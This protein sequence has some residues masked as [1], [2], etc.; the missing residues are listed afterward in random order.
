[1]PKEVPLLQ[2]IHYSDIHLAGANYVQTRWLLNRAYSTLSQDHQQGW[3]GAR[4]A[5]LDEFKLVIAALTAED[6]VWKDEPAWLVDT[7]DGTTFGDASSLTEWEE[8]TRKFELAAQ[9]YGRLMRVYG[10]H[11]G[12]PGTFPLFAPTRMEAQRDSLRNTHFSTKWPEAAWTVNVPGTSSRIELCAVNTVDHRLVP[13]TLALGVAARDH[14]W[15]LFQS[16][17]MDTPA[18]DLAQTAMALPAATTVPHLRIAAMHYPVA[19]EAT[20]GKPMGQKVLANR[21]RFADDLRSHPLLQPLVTNLLLAGHTHSPFPDLG[22]LPRSA[23]AAAHLPLVAGQ[24]QIVSGSLSQSV[25]PQAQRRPGSSWA[26]RMALDN[27]YQCTVLRFYSQPHDPGEIIMDRT[28]LGADDSAVFSYLPIAPASAAFAERM[29][30][31]L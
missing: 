18:D 14:H 3:A 28:I 5:V 24:C 31:R 8:W 21:T 7:G 13:N 1:M 15:K 25:A 12:W 10:N 22:L 11:D 16:I 17:P 26:K 20:P 19:H 2:I 9:P 6:P 23:T 4:R 29:T 30:F 27:P